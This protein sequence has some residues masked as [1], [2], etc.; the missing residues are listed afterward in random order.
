[1]T[2]YIFE[3][4]QFAP[5]FP[6][7]FEEGNVPTENDVLYAIK[8]E[9]P[10]D[11]DFAWNLRLYAMGY[12]KEW[13]NSTGYLDGAVL[14]EVPNDDD[15]GTSI[16]VSR[17][18]MGRLILIAPFGD[19]GNIVLF[20][21]YAGNKNIWVSNTPRTYSQIFDSALCAKIL[22][23]VTTGSLRAAQRR[24]VNGLT[25]KLSKQ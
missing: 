9:M 10:Q 4:A 7:L 25:K 11:T 16:Y 20:Q 18:P 2:T 17:C 6:A 8:A 21:R 5:I 24:L 3:A 23:L 12:D 22:G 13:E 19:Q 1:M 14:E 15:S